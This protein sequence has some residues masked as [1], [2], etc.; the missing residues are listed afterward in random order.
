M[1][2]LQKLRINFSKY[3][4]ANLDL[5]T[6]FIL[7][8]MTGNPY[9][10]N[11]VP[12]LAEIQA[13]LVK[14][15][16]ALESAKTRASLSVA[17]KNEARQ[18]LEGLLKDLGL[19]IMS[20][21][22]GNLAVLV[23]SGYPLTKVP[24]PRI[25]T[26]PGYVF[27]QKGISSGLLEASVKPEKPA[28]SY[29]YQICSTDPESGTEPVWISYVATSGKYVFTNLQPGKKYWVRIAAVGARGQVAYSGIF[30]EFVL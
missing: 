21:A 9:F 22:K 1:K 8:C 28:A 5:I 24:E 2:Q 11:P 23:S 13:A 15:R 30:S 19:F 3:T 26:N 4:D 14:Y 25:I 7:I 20:A 29:L 18:E 17:E 10:L 27:L 16:A 6:A 12:P